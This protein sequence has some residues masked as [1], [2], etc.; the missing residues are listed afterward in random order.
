M[1]AE[2]LERDPAFR[3]RP[4]GA[5]LVH[6]GPHRLGAGR[7][8]PDESLH[9]RM[10]VRLRRRDD[11]NVGR[12]AVEDA[13]EILPVMVDPVL[14]ATER[15]RHVDEPPTNVRPSVF[16]GKL[17]DLRRLRLP[18]VLRVQDEALER[19]AADLAE[20]ARQELAEGDLSSQSAN[21]LEAAD[22]QARVDDQVALLADERLHLDE[23]IIVPVRQLGSPVAQMGRRAYS[24]TGSR[25]TNQ[26]SPTSAATP[27]R[28]SIHSNP[29]D[30]PRKTYRSSSI[31]PRRNKV[32]ANSMKAR[33]WLLRD[34]RLRCGI[35]A[36]MDNL[37]PFPPT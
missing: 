13:S 4:P 24:L 30:L 32:T 15:V 31:S 7:E 11:P 19:I 17:R 18:F 3:V 6:D 37:S 10:L 5:V 36:A 21:V 1:L 23:E 16:A 14:V 22:A 33:S 8:I 26:I 28:A 35:H 29:P 20:A 9:L 2:R 27:G 12:E 34:F 25:D